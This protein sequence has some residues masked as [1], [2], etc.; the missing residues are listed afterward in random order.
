MFNV[1]FFNAAYFSIFL[2]HF[3]IC[4]YKDSIRLCYSAPISYYQNVAVRNVIDVSNPS[5][6]TTFTLILHKKNADKNLFLSSIIKYYNKQCKKNK[7]SKE[8][9]MPK[10][11]T[12]VSGIIE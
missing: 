12:E 10:K 7:Y 3:S 8:T 1:I 4:S 11:D 9:K 6:V 5:H 2:V